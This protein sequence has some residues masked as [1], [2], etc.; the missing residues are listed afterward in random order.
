M[1]VHF[2]FG[3]LVFYLNHFIQLKIEVGDLIHMFSD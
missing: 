2:T 1:F 3:L